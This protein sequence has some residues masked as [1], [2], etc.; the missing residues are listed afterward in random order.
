MKILLFGASGTAGGAVLQACLATPL[1]EEARVVVRRPLGRTE[2]KQREFVHTNFLDYTAVAEGFRAVD[3]C[4]F[5]LGISVTQVSREEFVKI[6]HDYAIAAAKMLKR[7]SPGAAFHYISGAGT[8]A[9]SRTFWSKVKGQTENELMELVE[10]DCW[11]PAF[12]D[13]KPSASLPKVYA[14]LRPAL[15]MLRP[16]RSL[17]VAGEDLGRAMLEAT[18]QGLRRRVFENAEIREL[19]ERFGAERN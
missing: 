8:R 10:A 19:A 4:L 12:I 1:V 17:Y 18:R 14:L 6:S 15:R 3:A 9:E 7:E 5:C 2:A 16:F 11:R 13:A